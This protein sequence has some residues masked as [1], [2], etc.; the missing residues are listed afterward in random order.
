MLHYIVILY[1]LGLSIHNM[2]TYMYNLCTISSIFYRHSNF[3]FAFPMYYLLLFILL[4]VCACVYMY[5]YIY[6]YIYCLI[7]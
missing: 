5:I 3:T 7:D 2:V 6:I 1:A 4:S